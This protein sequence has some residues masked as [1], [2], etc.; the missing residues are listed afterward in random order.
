MTEVSYP[1][2]RLTA[3]RDELADHLTGDILPYWAVKMSDPRGG[4]YGRRDGYDNLMEDAPKGA[5]LQAR[6]LWTMSA[7]YRLTGDRR[8]LEAARHAFEFVRDRMIDR[9]YGGVYWSV[10]A[11]GE[12]LDTHKQFYAI[13]FTIYGLAEYA[14]ATGDTGAKRLALDLFDV[15]ERHSRD[16]VNGGYIE[17]ASRDWQPLDDMRLS[18]KDENSS[19]SMNTHLHIIEAYTTLLRLC[20]GNERVREATRS[21]LETH[22]D[23]IVDPATGH[24]RLFFDDRFRPTGSDISYGHDIEASWLL[25]ETAFVLGDPALTERARRVTRKLADAAAEGRACDGS[26]LYERHQSGSY[27]CERHWWVQAEAAVGQAW[28]A[29]HHGRT[30]AWDRTIATWLW[31]KNHLLDCDCGEWFWSILPDGKVNRTD[32]KAGFWKCPYHNGRMCMEL[33]SMIYDLTGCDQSR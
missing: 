27:D 7:A 26:F 28:L 19:K 23:H 13:A 29:R 15:I 17:A 31:I 24:L 2:E 30:G 4:Y 1:A 25:L 21:L 18:E 5:I 14:L 32:D 3:L 9:E 6:V 20:P 16:R 8:W 10:T 33:I 12:P 22:L 11:E